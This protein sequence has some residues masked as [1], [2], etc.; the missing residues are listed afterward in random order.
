M[1]SRK[2]G[3]KY[4]CSSG[5]DVMTLVLIQSAFITFV[6][7]F[8]ALLPT[9][10]TFTHYSKVREMII[11]TRTIIFSLLLVSY[12]ICRFKETMTAKQN[13]YC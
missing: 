5:C 2:L 12:L 8:C 7:S 13:S 10:A 3:I 1:K 6:F 9:C 11:G 4:Y